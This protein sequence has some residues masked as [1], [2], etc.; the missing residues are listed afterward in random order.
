M[1]VAVLGDEVRVDDEDLHW[2]CLDL[3]VWM[4]WVAVVQTDAMCGISTSCGCGFP[5]PTNVLYIA[6]TEDVL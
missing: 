2:R 5:E 4:V 6:Y 1:A 3:Q